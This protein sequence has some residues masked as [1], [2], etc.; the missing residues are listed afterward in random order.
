[1]KVEFDL[2]EKQIENY[3]KAIDR[4]ERMLSPARMKRRRNE[5]EENIISFFHDLRVALAK[6]KPLDKDMPIGIDK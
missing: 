6:N 5:E 3:N 2:T 4:I 1:M